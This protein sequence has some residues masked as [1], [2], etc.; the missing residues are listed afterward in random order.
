MNNRIDRIYIAFICLAFMVLILGV[1][2]YGLAETSEARYAE[3]SREMLISGDYLNPE[4]LGIFHFHKPPMT[5]YLTILGYRI[6]GI[7]EF[8]A[9]FFIQVAIVIQ[10]VLVYGMARLLFEDRKVA[11]LSGTIYF[12]MPIVLISSRNLT[13][14]AYLTTFIMA[15]IFC[16]QVYTTKGKYVFLYLFYLFSGLALLTKGPVALLFVLVYIIIYK[17]IFKKPSPI[18]YHHL[19]G[20]VLCFIVGASWYVLVILNNPKL[21][22][23]FLEKQLWSRIGKESFNRSKPFWYYIPIVIGLLF[24]WILCVMP[25]FKSKIKS[26]YNL[27]TPQQ[28][29]LFSSGILCVLF[30]LFSTKLI[31]YILP[32]F[33]MLSIFI[34]SRLVRFSITERTIIATSYLVLLSLLF[35]TLLLLWFFSIGSIIISPLALIIMFLGVCIAAIA[36]RFINKNTFFKPV[37][38]ALVF[39]FSLLLVSNQIFRKNSALINST[40]EIVEFIERTS[41]AHKKTIVVYDYLLSSIPFYSDANLITLKYEHNTSNRETQFEKNEDWKESLW[42]AKNNQIVENIDSLTRK[43]ATYFLVRKQKELPESLKFLKANFNNKKA[44]PKW[45]LYYNK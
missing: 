36:Y 25:N 29:L 41:I 30:S 17:I 43:P 8:G 13:T 19:I 23:Y 26:I 44:F 3:I 11:F 10:L 22:D 1:G 42:D 6:F 4:L 18:T 5:Y 37:F 16:W 7:T 14:D 40:K 24:P 12:F 45:T 27:S 35:A 20:F 34:A 38:M 15:S 28:T 31:L 33:W 2:S 32:V 9:R 39:S 21:W